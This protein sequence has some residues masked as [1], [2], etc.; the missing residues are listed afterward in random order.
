MK[1]HRSSSSR[2]SKLGA[3]LGCALVLMAPALIS[4]VAHAEV[5]TAES[6]AAGAGAGS[7]H[8][9]QSL[10]QRLDTLQNTLQITSDQQ[11]AWQA[12]TTAVTNQ[13]AARKAW[14][15][16]NPPS[17]TLTLPQRL[18]RR[19][20]MQSVLQ[21]GQQAVSAALKQLYAALSPAQQL[22]LELKMAHQHAAGHRHWG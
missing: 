11:G 7:G 17:A 10:Q 12:Y 13:D 9:Q 22:T 5:G 18:D 1:M 15:A 6:T 2:F 4:G 14:F 21:P 3:T 16:A 19:A 8:H 20:S